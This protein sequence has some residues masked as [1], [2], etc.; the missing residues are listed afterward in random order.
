MY[1][2]LNHRFGRRAADVL[3]PVIYTAMALAIVYCVF[4]EQASFRYLNF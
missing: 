3:A 2:M 1:A 4:E